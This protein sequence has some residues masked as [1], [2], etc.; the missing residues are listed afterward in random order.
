MI[1][2][3]ASDGWWVGWVLDIDMYGVNTGG[4]PSIILGIIFHLNINLFLMD[5]LR[6]DIFCYDKN[7]YFVMLLEVFHTLINII[8]WLV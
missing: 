3:L 8:S 7:S 6:V 2:I 1:L 5:I 4:E